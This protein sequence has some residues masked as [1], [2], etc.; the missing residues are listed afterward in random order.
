[1]LH[2]FPLF[3]SLI[4]FWVTDIVFD[5]R[6]SIFIMMFGAAYSY[7]N[8]CTTKSQGSPVYWFLSWED[9]TSIYIC[10]GL[11]MGVTLIFLL[12]AWLQRQLKG[13]FS[14]KDKQE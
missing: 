11:V 14:A 1:M 5:P 4:H 9:E 10:T 13:D 6:H 3:S 2:A 7:A 12:L 8:Y